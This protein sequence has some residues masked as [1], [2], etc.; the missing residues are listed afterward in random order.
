MAPARR[1]KKQHLEMVLV[2]CCLGRYRYTYPGPRR[3]RSTSRAAIVARNLRYARLVD[4]PKRAPL[5]ASI[6]SKQN[7]SCK[8]RSTSSRAGAPRHAVAKTLSARE[9]VAHRFD[10]VAP[11]T[12]S[13]RCATQSTMATLRGRIGWVIARKAPQASEKSLRNSTNLV[14]VD[15]SEMAFWVANA[16]TLGVIPLVGLTHA[17]HSVFGPGDRGAPRVCSV[18]EHGYALAPRNHDVCPS[19]VCRMAARLELEPRA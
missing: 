12:T 7:K 11:R 3:Y 9:R 6:K 5:R 14:K 19:Q 10:G 17:I 16:R 2:L 15:L 4:T 1:C 18:R 13:E 8:P